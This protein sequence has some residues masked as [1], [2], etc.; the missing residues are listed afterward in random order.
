MEAILSSSVLTALKLLALVAGVLWFFETP[1]G[2]KIGRYLPSPFWI[3]FLSILLATAGFFPTESPTYTLIEHHALPIAI[4]LM[5]IGTPISSLFRIGPRALVAM[6]LAT[7]TM[8]AAMVGLYVVVAHYL[9]EEGWKACGAL[10]GTW[11]GGSA[12]MLAVKQI[13][14]LSDGGF[15]P[16]IVVDTILSYAW[17]ALILACVRYQDQ[18]DRGLNV[19]IETND[20]AEKEENN[21]M[22]TLPRPIN[23]IAV[24]LAALAITEPLIAAGRVTATHVTLLSAGGWGILFAST[25]AL[26]LAFTPAR[27]LEKWEASRIGTLALYVVLVTIGAKTNLFSVVGVPAYL[28]F[29]TAVLILHGV[30][31]LILGRL[32]RVPLFLLLT[33][34]QANVGGVVSAPIV[35]TVYKPGT[36][37]VGVVMAV[38]GAVLGTYL[39]VA[40]GLL[41]HAL[42]MH[43]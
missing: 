18:F 8:F 7:G 25:A 39:G 20:S 33:A 41:C 37:H 27:R 30:S 2:E 6:A 32:C 16:L 12:N 9:P 3:Y 28:I 36:A 43:P 5:L 31:L 42:I 15:T 38:L 13:L 34:S 40:G 22:P 17:L 29:G 14:S 35:A 24:T 23:W 26:L 19:P 4:I 1:A 11:I 10:L 21:Q